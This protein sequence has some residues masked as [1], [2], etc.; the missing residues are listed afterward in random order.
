MNTLKKFI[1]N[2]NK[3]EINTIKNLQRIRNTRFVYILD[4]F[5]LIASFLAE[6]EYYIFVLPFIYWNI[7]WMLGYQLLNIINYGLYIGNFIKIKYKISRP[8]NVW[9]HPQLKKLD[10]TNLQDYSFPSTHSMNAITNISVLIIYNQNNK[11]FDESF[12]IYILYFI[13]PLS[14]ILS[15][16]YLGAH[17]L[18]DIIGGCI[19]GFIVVIIWN[20]T[21]VYI[22]NFY[23][24]SNP[25]LL[26]VFNTFFYTLLF[27]YSIGNNKIDKSVLLMSENLGAIM[28]NQLGISLLYTIH[29]I[30]I[31]KNIYLKQTLGLCLLLIVKI[32]INKCF[33]IYESYYTDEKLKNII[34]IVEKY[35]V[36][37]ILAFSVTTIIPNI[38]NI[39]NL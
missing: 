2:R 38:F 25:F 37:L 12:Y 3:T 4:M 18:I 16:I 6:E 31:K 28:G 35:F 27:Y 21:N 5:F 30:D 11:L 34:K 19:L 8:K 17:T 33:I 1:L 10:S 29:P 24:N 32:F 20:L 39:T 14:I 15:R 9:V 13:Y 22:D 23:L 26:L 7:D 36:H